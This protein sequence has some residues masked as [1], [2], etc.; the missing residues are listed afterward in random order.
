MPL[1]N[2][3][4]LRQF[5]CGDRAKFFVQMEFVRDPEPDT[6]PP[7]ESASWGR[8]QIWAGG[9]NLCLHYVDGISQESVTWHLLP[10]LEWL[11]EDWDYLLHEQRYPTRNVEGSAGIALRSLNSPENF[12]GPKGWNRL[13]AKD[14]DDWT[15]RHSLLMHRNG[16]IFPDVWLRR[17]GSQIE[18]SW[19]ADHPPGV[20]QGFRF[21]NGDGSLLLAPH[22]VADPLYAVLKEASAAL[23]SA[24]PQSAR[25]KKLVERVDGIKERSRAELRVGILA[26]LGRTPNEWQARWT[27]LSEAARKQFKRN[28]TQIAALFQPQCDNGIVVGGEC[29]AALMFGSAC[30]SLETKDAL[31]LAG[32]LLEQEQASEDALLKHVRN[33]PLDCRLPPWQQGYALAQ[34]WTVDEREPDNGNAVDI[35]RHLEKLGVVIKKIELSDSSIGAVSMAGKQK[36]P[37]IAVNQAN[38]RNKSP[39]GWRFTL[40]HELCHLLHDRSRGVELQFVSGEWAPVEIE[41]RANAFAAGLLMSDALV[42]AAAETERVRLPNIDQHGLEGMARRLD[43][44]VDALG[45]HLVNRGWSRSR[46]LENASPDY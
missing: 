28:N 19:T 3:N 46:I 21:N 10:V 13:A 38:P 23:N 2:P 16:G 9:R 45:H 34:E 7:E 42:L 27:A 12:E 35:E 36:K 31:A 43:V 22:D 14:V 33:A 25:L 41:M 18:I 39:G 26:A 32:L 44:S 1:D 4:L 20:P 8:L 29:S 17:L 5:G 11:A 37:V 6:A 40:A 15:R 24:L 30:P